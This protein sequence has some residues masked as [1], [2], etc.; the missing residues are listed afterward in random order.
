MTRALPTNSCW[1]G[2]AR[3]LTLVELLIVMVIISI[4]AGLMMGG[5]QKTQNL[6]REARTKATIAKLHHFI[7]LK[8][9]SYK[10]RRI[11]TVDASAICARW[12]PPQ[13]T[14]AIRLFAIRDLMRMEMPERWRTSPTGRS[15]SYRRVS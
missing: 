14:A 1:R 8:M 5:M 10:T 15:I 4:M 2:V 13:T 6:A 12:V 3:G 11:A 7:T 9:E